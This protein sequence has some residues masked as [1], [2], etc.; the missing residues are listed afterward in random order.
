M[1]VD[2]IDIGKFAKTRRKLKGWTQAE[3]AE[4]IHTFRQAISDIERGKAKGQVDVFIRYMAELNIKLTPTV[5]NEPVFEELSTL[6]P[7]DDE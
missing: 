4:R 5:R 3:A 6:F 1:N 7:L 2:L